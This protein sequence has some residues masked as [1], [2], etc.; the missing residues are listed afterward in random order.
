M[1][2]GQRS[3]FFKCNILSFVLQLSHESTCLN[4][5]LVSLDF[6]CERNLALALLPR[7]YI[8]G[9]LM[10]KI[11]ILHKAL[12]IVIAERYYFMRCEQI[13]FEKKLLELSFFV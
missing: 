6:E 8:L 7:S 1:G 10:P 3:R 9:I 13:Q 5:L 4:W 12:L 11:S 2:K